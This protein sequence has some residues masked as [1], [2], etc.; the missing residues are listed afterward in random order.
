MKLLNKSLH[1]IWRRIPIA[2][3]VLVISLITT[4]WGWFIVKQANQLQIRSTVF[5][6][7]VERIKNSILNRMFLYQQVLEGGAGLFAA[8]V[9]VERY[10]WY[11][12]VQTLHLEKNYSGIQ[13]VGFS[14]R[15]LPQ[16]LAKH[17]AEIRAEGGFFANYTLRPAGEREEYTSII[18]LEPLDKR[19][20]QAIGY[21]M[22][23]EP[24]RHQAMA[25]ARDTGEAALSGKVTLV[26]ETDKDVQA[27][28]LLYIPVYRNGQPHDTV[29]E[30]RA[31]LVGYV[32]S[33]FRMNNLM[34]GIFGEH[35]DLQ[36]DFHI[37]DSGDINHLTPDKLMYDEARTYHT[38]NDPFN[39]SPQFTR[40]DTLNI[41]GH[42]WTIQ[43]AT[44]P[45]FEVATH[46]Y[47][48]HIV[49]FGGL[50]V[51]FL[52]FGMTRS[53]ETTRSLVASRQAN[54]RLQ[55]EIRERHQVEQALQQSQ[56]RFD[57]AMRGSNDGLWDWNLVTN[58]VYFSPRWKEMLG[59][60]DHEIPHHLN[61][62]SK[63]VHPDDL[64]TTMSEVTAYLEKQRPFY[65]NIHRVQHKDGHYV[66]ILD[67]G[68][69][70]WNTEGKP[71]RMV[72]IHTD[73]TTLKQA[74]EALK[75]SEERFMAVLDNLPV[76]IYL[77]APDYSIRFANRLFHERFGD[78]T[79]KTCYEVIRHQTT[80]CEECAVRCVFKQP[81]A[82]QI[83]ESPLIDGHV[84][85]IY[86]YPFVDRDGSLLTL[87]MGLDITARKEAETAL[88]RS[89]DELL[90]YFE[91]PLVGMLS[92][93]LKKKS[94]HINQ[95]FCDI[96]GYNKEEMQI[97]DW[98]KITHPDD[99]VIDQVY[100]DQVIRGKIDSYEMEKRYI[101]KDGHL[102]YVHLA[103]NGVR[104]E[105]GQ[106]DY[107]IA[108][109][110]DISQR[111]Q[112]EQALEANRI[113]LHSIINSTPDFIYMKDL[114][115]RYLLFNTASERVVGKSMAEV[116]GKDDYFL[117]PPNEAKT[118][119]AS[120]RKALEGQ[121]PITYE[122]VVTF[123]SGEVKT[124]LA[125]KG[126]VFNP[127]GEKIG[128]FGIVRD[129]TERKKAEEALLKSQEQYHSLVNNIP[130]YVMRY[131]RQCRHVFAN[132][133]A[134]KVADKTAEEY[135]GK[136]HRE[137]GFP[138]YL[139]A[140]WENAIARCFE[141]G[142]PQLE[143]FEWESAVGIVVLEWR[144][145]PE[146]TVEHWMETVLAISRDITERMRAELALQQ[147]EAKYRQIVETSQ[148]GIWV[149][150]AAAKTTYVNA[151]MADMLGYSEADML[152][153]SVFDFMDDT[154][155]QEAIQRF[156]H[157]QQGLGEIHDF[158]F[159]RKDGS[160]LWAIVSTTV[161]T[162]EAGHFLGSL[163]MITDITQRKQIE[164][165]LQH[166]KDAAD[167]A[168]RAKST[169]L[170]NMS[171]EL[172]TPLN[173]ILGY[174]QILRRHNSLTEEQRE[175][176]HV[177]EKSGEYLLTLINDILDLAKVEAGKIEL[178]PTVVVLKEFL[179]RIVQLF[180][181]RA[182]QKGLQF[183]YQPLSDLPVAI[184][185]DEKRLQQVLINL[186]GNAFKF[187]ER[188]EVKLK[189]AY[190][191]GELYFQIEDQGCGIV[192]ADL[193]KIF[194]PFQQVGDKKYF[195]QG[196]G[197]GLPITKKLVD[198]M[199]GELRVTSTLGQGSTFSI[200]LKLSQVPNILLP[201]GD[202]KSP[203]IIG[204]QGR[205]RTVLVIDDNLVNRSILIKLLTSLGFI[206]LE[207]T[208]GQAG[209]N[210]AQEIPAMD[211]ILVDLVMPGLDGFAV[212]QQ[213][214][215]IPHCRETVLIAMSASVF[216]MDRQKSLELGC[217]D[218][219]AKPIKFDVFLERLRVHLNLNW[220]YD[221]TMTV[222]TTS[223][224]SILP[225]EVPPVE[226]TSA[227]VTD[228]L[229]L[230]QTGDVQN[231][232]EYTKELANTKTLA[233]FARY[234]HQLAE[235]F[236]F[237]KICEI[238]E[239]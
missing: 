161:M 236:E 186:L 76:F 58:E 152:G 180:E 124:L 237:E 22:F 125:T 184:S 169:F 23:A 93:N 66:W 64:D 141:T 1:D 222:S 233:D 139:C 210:Q 198:M 223:E 194:Q 72:G 197:L 116:L 214:R 209:L 224:E 123:A 32:Y 36:I 51:S 163:G 129:F 41:A 231:V 52:L 206:L 132:E 229:Y 50:L 40:I 112:V 160:D 34:R 44:L 18:Y 190:Q 165:D 135:I 70:V 137:M 202:F 170:A 14:K 138:E 131:D 218:F 119:M 150:D 185:V 5:D 157:R 122:E 35:H 215:Q 220:L 47:T 232:M 48:A 24:T 94:L 189:V 192:A 68:I 216:E 82:P 159:R 201:M 187:T 86:S 28:C 85:E 213:V 37:Y 226:L 11:D 166:A 149:I 188:G 154:A 80:P 228:L 143:I 168:N 110:L 89:R 120:D 145:I 164:F 108:M 155:R 199:G 130:D 12:Y 27:G 219:I 140:L 179:R 97:L 171:H 43:F 13:G 146:S 158:R 38:K 191:P 90:C 29:A 10:E 67:R 83:R 176:I 95:R 16:D 105:Q 196:T 56:E 39:Y 88:R 17:Q 71:V 128:L 84:Y 81:E 238:L 54:A 173:G 4:L 153:K 193:D 21:D 117:F 111:K 127:A 106:I 195:G 63:R 33:P 9:S 57:L 134:I 55:K 144:V 200:L 104:D 115:G 181:L 126:P 212:I 114:Q 78:P 77:Q 235:Q 99:L 101:H 74:E 7:R 25:R 172:R 107:F 92:S 6:Y 225:I 15:I 61:E 234:I 65:E 62:W 100:F 183:S 8:S 113:L 79:Q 230:A 73:L 91:Q 19:N 156:E 142:T 59:Y 103:V 136:T 26:Q 239:K 162:D 205:P 45:E 75:K 46:T 121:S 109:V 175:G 147:S 177:I 217:H 42:S 31:A 204:Y 87:Q 118:I 203:K 49:W 69:A 227:Q 30:K 211:L 3:L 96:V 182:E 151:K 53:L 20:Q 98:G 167:V 133:R 178:S 60:A 102:V 2:W 221:Q 207:A 148:E 174:A 208:D